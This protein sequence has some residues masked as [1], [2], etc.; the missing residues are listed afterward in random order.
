MF[1]YGHDVGFDSHAH[2]DATHARSSAADAKSTVQFLQKEVDRLALICEAQWE[3]LK[4]KVGVTDD[5]LMEQIMMLDLSDGK[6]DGK[7]T[8][9]PLS[10][11]QCSKNN[12]RRHDRCIY[13]GS[14]LRS[15]PFD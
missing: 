10:C 14:M 8:Q 11:P 2:A 12:A 3:L 5:E 9:G 4:T 15:K 7:V 1:Y 6:L 13:C